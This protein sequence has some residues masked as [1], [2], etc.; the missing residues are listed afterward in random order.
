METE[1]SSIAA[2]LVD[3]DVT[4]DELASY[5]DWNPDRYLAAWE[6]YRRTGRRERSFFAMG[7][8]G[9]MRCA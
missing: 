6:N 4:A 2:N 9:E 1:G 7:T 3:D 5:V 8:M